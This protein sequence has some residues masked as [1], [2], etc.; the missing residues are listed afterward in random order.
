MTIKDRATQWW[1]EQIKQGIHVV[2]TD[3]TPGQRQRELLVKEK[4]LFRITKGYWILKRSED[5]VEEIFP[6]LYWQI[7]DK[8]LTRYSGWAVQGQSALTVYN[9]NQAPQKNLRIRTQEK[10]NNKLSL[11]AERSLSLTYDPDFDPRLVRKTDIAGV[12]IPIDVPEKVL[13]DARK[14]EP[15]PEL[16]NFIAGTRF[17]VRLLEAIYAKN[18]KPVVFKRLVGMAKEANRPDLVSSLE[19]MIETHTHYRVSRKEM[20]EELYGAPKKAPVLTPP[21]VIRQESQVKEFA[22]SLQA[23]LTDRIDSLQKFSVDVLLAQAKEHKR[24]DTYHSTTLEGYRITPE[25]V[26]ALLSGIT[27]KDSAIQGDKYFEELKNRLAILGYSEAFDFIISRIKTDTG[28]PHIG[29][30]LIKDTYY[31]LFKPSADAEII[32]YLDLVSYREMPAFIRGTSHVPPSKDKV[33]ALMASFESTINAVKTPAIRAILAH[34]FFVTIHPYGDGNGRTA[35]LLMNY[36]LMT[37]GYRWLT[38]RADQRTPY[39]D[40]LKA[41]QVAGNIIPFGEFIVGIL[42]KVYHDLD[43]LAGTWSPE[44]AEEFERHLEEQRRIDEDVWR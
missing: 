20:V 18:P 3:E 10:T 23:H 11:S 39:F 7:I 26:D 19:Q 42:E 29:E 41:G 22:E 44:E 6:L 25:E 34:Y 13:V 5:Q 21:W 9:G 36:L 30:D 28:H 4:F 16:S 15:S 27:P 14:L 31:Y 43:S 37:S 1:G 38:I 8:I 32:D 17:D 40:A 35:R 33:P 2:S 12:D 24:Y